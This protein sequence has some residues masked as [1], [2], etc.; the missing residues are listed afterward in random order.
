MSQATS[1]GCPIV[2]VTTLIDECPVGRFQFLTILLC[3]LLVF[4][5]GYDAQAIAYAAPA[6]RAAWKI[7][8]GGLVPVFGAG[9]AGIMLGSL[10]I[11]PLADRFGRRRVILYATFSFALMMLMT[12]LARSTGM[13]SAMRFLTGVG[14]GG[15]MANVVA[16]TAEYSPSRRRTLFIM[17]M[18][19]G[20]SLG[21]A[22]G[23]GVAVWLIPQFG[24]PSVFWFGG[25]M[26]LVLVPFLIGFL[27][28]SISFLVVR[29]SADRTAVRLF[30]RLGLKLAPNVRII[31]GEG[32]AARG[33]VFELFSQDRGWITI[34]IWVIFFMNLLDLNLIVAW[35]P[36]TLLATG[37]ATNQ[38]MIA[39]SVFQISGMIGAIVLAL[40]ST[41]LGTG[42]ILVV[43]N[44]I[45]AVSILLVADMH[46]GSF[47]TM[48]AVAGAGFGVVGGQIAANALPATFY[49]TFVRATGTGWALGIGR[50][51]S[52]VGPV[53]GGML[54]AM[55]MQPRQ[56][57]SLCVIPMIVAAL[58]AVLV[59]RALQRR[60]AAQRWATARATQ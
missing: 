41:R 48:F 37:T 24:W 34:L 19:C 11:A 46:N 14:I 26:S 43:G 36:T 17:L 47:E 6:I 10:F 38:A 8:N 55:N 54:L 58:A 53:A 2:N 56:F 5:E 57:F 18:F 50:I 25:L 1:D 16:L 22:A 32:S 60:A 45:A 39:G 20:F 12:S 42:W 15:A 27:P 33:S 4:A 52:I 21:S 9:M 7:N 13:L 23:G 49:P 3:G 59:Q 44:I 29:D 40:T 35:L 28:E 31:L 30:E 51:G